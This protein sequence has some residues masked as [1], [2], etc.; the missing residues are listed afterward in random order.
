M[1]MLGRRR[2]CS[3]PSR[4]WICSAVYATSA[5]RGWGLRLR[6]GSGS[7]A[8][9]TGI[10]ALP[11]WR[12]RRGQLGRGSGPQFYAISSSKMASGGL[13]TGLF[14]RWFPTEDRVL[15]QTLQVGVDLPG[16]GHLVEAPD[17]Q[18]V[19]LVTQFFRALVSLFDDLRDCCREGVQGRLALAL[20]GLATDHLRDHERE[21]NGRGIEIPFQETFGHIERLDP[22]GSQVARAGD[23]LVHA[24]ALIREVDQA[25][26]A[27]AQIVGRD[28]GVHRGLGKPVAAHRDYV[29]VCADQHAEVSVEA[30]HSPDRLR[31]LE[32]ELQVPVH[33]LHGRRRQERHQVRLH[34][35]WAGARP[36]PTMGGGERLVEV[37]VHAL[38]A[39][40][41]GAAYAPE[42]GQL[43]AVGVE[44]GSVRL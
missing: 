34:P 22:V 26:D 13:L 28:H 4:T 35:H 38:E 33:S 8:L 21:V 7:S 11:A 5:P 19:G 23:E 20:A 24:R 2:T 15:A 44:L 41:P 32:I 43:G 42:R 29:G 1:Y 12:T 14:A 31:P 16:G 25:F 3:R 30:A 17:R 9:L 18:A 40:V 36:A 6:T 39:H 10:S 37:H 27:F